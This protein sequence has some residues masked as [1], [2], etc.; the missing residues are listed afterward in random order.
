MRLQVILIAST[1]AACGGGGGAGNSNPNPPGNS[2]VTPIYAIQGSG[3]VSPLDGQSVT[4]EGVV[5]G[6]F[7][8]SDADTARNL[9]GFYIQNVP[10]ADLATSDG[11]FIFDGSNPQTDV[12]A[13]DLV[14]I[15]GT[16]NEYFGETQVSANVVTVT[17]S[18]SIQPAAINLPA[19]ATIANSDG[20]LIA[21]LERYEGMLLRFP[22]TL[23]VS[24]LYELER[25]GEVLLTEGGRPFHFTNQNAPDVA[26]YDIHREA[27]A[28]RQILL[29]DGKRELNAT[30][31]RYLAAGA[32]PDYSIRIGDQVTD[33]TGVLR[34]SRGSGS[35]GSETYRLMPT[36]DPLFEAMNPRPGAPSVNGAL[37]VATFNVLNF[38]SGIDSGQADCG[39]SGNSNCRGADSNEE[40]NRQLGKMVTTLS[41]MNADIVGLIEL[42]NNASESLQQIVDALNVQLGAGTYAFVDAGTIGD[43]AIKTGFIYKPA[44]VISV[45][46]P[47]ILDSSVDPGFDDSKNR[48]ALAQTFEQISNNAQLTIVNNH[49]KSKASAC[50]AVGDPNTGDGQKN[51]NITRT[52]AATA[53]VDWLATD[54]TASGDADFLVIGDLNAYLLEDPVTALKNAGF[55]N[56]AENA[57]GLVAYS[58]SFDAQSGALDHALASASL[59]TQVSDVVEWH[60]NADEPPVL[61]YNLE[62]NRDPSLFDS[63]SPYRTSDHD[64]LIVGLDLNP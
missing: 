12:I 39:P 44:N 28:A 24:Q 49:L 14:R 52:T 31:V 19:A 41:M 6:D 22:Q 1:L 2:V 29:D 40:F 23:T 26:G 32:A 37:H 46:M 38:F 5:T 58:Y 21:D 61:D 16:I 3:P 30:P 36:G 54:P 13:G 57:S 55:V 4:V 9:G 15:D 62:G 35:S 48:P 7:Q 18:G 56:L 50:D 43:G 8:D 11:V 59:A 34:F 10:D 33:V 51:C 45:G 53:I 47:A 64:P 60:I 63:S 17:G 42:E 25:T 27:I 20:G